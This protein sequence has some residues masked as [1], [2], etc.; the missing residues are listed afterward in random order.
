[1]CL[2]G[3]SGAG[4]ELVAAV[5]HPDL[6]AHYVWAPLLPPGGGGSGPGFAW[7]VYLASARGAADLSAPALWM[8]QLGVQDA[9]RLDAEAFRSGVE[10]LLDVPGSEAPAGQA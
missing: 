2:A 1:M 8:H 6:R 5:A 4:A 7:D 9:P 10:R 3:A